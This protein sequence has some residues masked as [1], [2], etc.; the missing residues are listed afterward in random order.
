MMWRDDL[1]ALVISLS[2]ARGLS[3]TRE[4]ILPSLS[5]CLLS[6]HSL[7]T[8]A[9]TPEPSRENAA[10]VLVSVAVLVGA[11]AFGRSV[12]VAAVLLSVGLLGSAAGGASDGEVTASVRRG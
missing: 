3:C 2:G 10:V 12:L 9:S 6:S 7:V 5:S 11:M 8:L 1:E 4:G